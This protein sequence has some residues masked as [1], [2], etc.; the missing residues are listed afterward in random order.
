MCRFCGER[1][2]LRRLRRPSAE[3]CV[4]MICTIVAR[5]RSNCA[6]HRRDALAVRLRDSVG[7]QRPPRRRRARTARN[8]IGLRRSRC[9][10]APTA[11]DSPV[12][13]EFE[14][15]LE[16]YLPA[17]R[18][19]LSA[20]GIHPP[21]VLRQCPCGAAAEREHAATLRCVA[22]E[23]GTLQ[24]TASAR[25]SDEASSFVSPAFVSPASVFCFC[26]P[27]ALLTAFALFALP[28][29]PSLD[30]PASPR[31]SASPPANGARC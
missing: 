7:P 10:A 1:R 15:Y 5:P 18:E 9:A 30:R 14:A 28:I 25:Q 26:L 2:W 6:V 21:R 8:G 12:F 4:A 24:Q 20:C 13:R 19:Y 17:V 27:F 11:G 23:H 3:T 22:T 29:H 16:E 31:S